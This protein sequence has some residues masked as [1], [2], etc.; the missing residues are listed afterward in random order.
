MKRKKRSART[1]VLTKKS[2]LLTFFNILRQPLQTFKQA[3]P[4]GGTTE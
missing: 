2:I 4:C 3:F 1:D